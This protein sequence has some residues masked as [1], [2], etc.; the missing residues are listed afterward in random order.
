MFVKTIKKGFWYKIGSQTSSCVSFNLLT[1]KMQCQ[2][3]AV[4]IFQLL[5]L[6]SV[7]SPSLSE[8]IEVTNIFPEE[9][10]REIIKNKTADVLE[11]PTIFG[12][13]AQPDQFPYVGLTITYLSGTNADQTALCTCSLVTVEYV[14]YA[15]HCIDFSFS[16]FQFFFGSTDTQNFPMFRN[17]IRYAINPDYKS[18]SG[19]YK[20]DIALA[21]LQTPVIPSTNVQIAKLPSRL[22]L[23]SSYEDKSLAA[24]G[25]GLDETGNLPRFLKYSQLQGQPDFQ[26][27]EFSLNPS[28]IC[29][30]STEASGICFGDSGGPLVYENTLVGINDILIAQNMENSANQESSCASGYD[31]FTRVDRYLDWIESYTKSS[32]PWF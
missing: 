22:S 5:V 1:F 27:G 25:F 11:E 29:A 18:N 20:N 31:A 6:Q 7:F 32:I 14:I 16:G 26:C 19:S 3:L 2:T 4:S 12:E 10:G 28:L 15:A 30:K 23:F 17:G 8:L 21:Q 24:V 13:F 9:L